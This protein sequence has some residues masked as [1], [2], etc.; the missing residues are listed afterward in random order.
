MPLKHRPDFNQALSTLQR[1]QQEAREEPQV[2]T[3][4]Y[5]HQQWEARRS[6]ST[7]WI[8]QGSWWTHYHSESQ[9]GDEPNIE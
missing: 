5:K 2:P 3:Y 6:S 4:S 9:D 8:R 7:W 1:L